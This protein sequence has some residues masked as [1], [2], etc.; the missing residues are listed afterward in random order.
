MEGCLNNP[1]NSSTTKI[2][3]HIPLGYSLSTISS[4]KDIKNKHDYAKVKIEEELKKGKN[5]KR[6]KM[7]LLPN[8]Q[9]ESNENPKIC[10]ICRG[11]SEDKHGKDKKYCKVRDHCNYTGENIE[12]LHIANV[13]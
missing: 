11:K 5:L 13:T 9:Q 1:E 2:G 12:V 7:K 4:F 6:K 8:K 3:E 10:Y